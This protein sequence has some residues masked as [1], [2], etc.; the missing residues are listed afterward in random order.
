MKKG[1]AQ[2]SKASASAKTSKKSP[3]AGKSS[4]FKNSK[5]GGKAKGKRK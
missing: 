2:K 4:Q 1:K 3:Y 5:K